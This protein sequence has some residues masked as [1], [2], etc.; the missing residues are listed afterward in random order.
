FLHGGL[1]SAEVMRPLSEEL[2]GY[3][4]YAPE[5]PGH[6]R[7]A[8]RPSPFH[9]ADGVADTVAV[10][11]ALGLASAH[12]VGFSDGAIIGL[13][14]ALGHPDRVRSLVAISGNLRAGDDVYVPEDERH[15]TMPAAEL[16]RVE[17]EYAR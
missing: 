12:V 14:L 16:A 17:E 8:D 3:A 7:T 9:Y 4:V 11:D 15:Y 2:D 5:R 1:C 10:L 13:L 6:G